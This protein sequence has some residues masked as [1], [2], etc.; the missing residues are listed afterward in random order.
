MHI[1]K[2]SIAKSDSQLLNAAMQYLKRVKQVDE[3]ENN[4]KKKNRDQIHPI[5]KR[6]VPKSRC[7]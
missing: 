7:L 2:T 6:A 4:Q 3:R 1:R 5:Y